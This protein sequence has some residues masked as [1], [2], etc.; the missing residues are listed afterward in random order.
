MNCGV[1]QILSAAASK[2]GKLNTWAIGE[3]VCRGA[4][5]GAPLTIWANRRLPF[6]THA[7]RF[8]D[9]GLPA[10][11]VVLI[12]DGRLRAFTSSQRYAGYLALPATGAFGDIEVAAGKTPAAALLARTHGEIVTFS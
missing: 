5:S 9:E 8:D 4:V 1:I 7:A 3:P 10:Q 6:G 12:E 2:F 11:R